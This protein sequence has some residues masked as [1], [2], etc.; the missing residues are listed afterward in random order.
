MPE[1]KKEPEAGWE[2]PKVSDYEK[3]LTRFKQIVGLNLDSLRNLINMSYENNPKSAKE[4]RTLSDILLATLKSKAE[5]LEGSGHEAE[6]KE[7]NQKLAE[8]EKMVNSFQGDEPTLRNIF[9]GIWKA[10]ENRK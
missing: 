9:L 3:K 2:Q 10:A 6:A 1:F 4:A 5:F 7:L 8:I